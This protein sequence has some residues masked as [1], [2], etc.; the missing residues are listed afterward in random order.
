MR[1]Y[2]ENFEGAEM[3]KLTWRQGAVG[4]AIVMIAIG[5]AGCGGDKDGGVTT[6]QLEIEANPSNGGAVSPEGAI[7]YNVGT[8]ANVTATANEGYIFTGWSGASTSSNEFV[9]VTMNSNQTLTANFEKFIPTFTDS[10][11]GKTYRRVRIGNIT[12][13]A[14]NLNHATG[15]SWCYEDNKGNCEKYGR[16]YDLST[17]MSACPPG[18]RLPTRIDWNDLVEIADGSV[19]GTRLKSKTDWNGTDEFGFSALPG[20]YRHVDGY[21]R[22]AGNFGFWWRSD[23]AGDATNYGR[24]R[25]MASGIDYVDAAIHN[26]GYGHSVRC[27]QN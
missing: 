15:N 13:M 7:R 21:F 12:W 2:I 5:F 18:W 19:A 1:E 24:F 9:T 6:F 10:R 17:A 20:G 16:L 27:A 11:D 4:F 22:F 23:P 14:E 25:A 8:A 26:K 3:P